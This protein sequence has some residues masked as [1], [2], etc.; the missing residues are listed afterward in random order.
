MLYRFKYSLVQLYTCVSNLLMWIKAQ[1]N[2]GF[3]YS[4]IRL[5]FEYS[6]VKVHMFYSDKLM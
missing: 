1:T 4:N 6:F 2:S 3:R 5:V